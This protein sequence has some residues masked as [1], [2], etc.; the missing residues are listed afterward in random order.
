MTKNI[1]IASVL[2]GILLLGGCS[3]DDNTGD[4]N[5]EKVIQL[6]KVKIP[7]GTFL[8]GSSDGS[9]IDDSDGSGLNTTTAEANRSVEPHHWVTLTKD[10]YMS[11]YLIT[12]T[13]YAAFLNDTG[14]GE[15]RKYE[16]SGYG[17]RSLFSLDSDWT[18]KWNSSKSRWEASGDTPMIWVTWFGA[19]AYAD[20]A[21]GALPTE[22]QWEYACRA[23]TTTAYSF[24]NDANDLGDYAW[25]YDNSPS[26]INGTNPVGTKLPNPW[27]LYDMHGNVWEWC[28]DYFGAWY[29]NDIWHISEAATDPIGPASPETGNYRV[30]RGGSWG[31]VAQYCRSAC[32]TL[33]SPTYGGSNFGFRVVFVP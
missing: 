27:G 28:S 17:S 14:V 18:P 30:L 33:G 13:Q 7:A 26:V 19:K 32:R 1:V 24:G 23:G 9:N 6:E 2:A 16:V 31:N 4:D 8:M 20:W 12:K 21:G 25:Y 29:G 11:K 15:D 22:A 10:Y 5:T 3:Q